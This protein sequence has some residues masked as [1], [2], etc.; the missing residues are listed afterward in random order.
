MNSLTSSN[1]NNNYNSLGSSPHNAIGNNQ[2][3]GIASSPHNGMG[4]NPHN[5]IGN[6]AHNGI[7]NNAHNGIGSSPHN[8]L[9]TN[10]PNGNLHN[11]TNVT[12]NMKN[13]NAYGPGPPNHFNHIGR[14][15]P[16][17]PTT[18]NN[19]N[20][21]APAATSTPSTNNHPRFGGHN[22]PTHHPPTATSPTSMPG[23][24]PTKK[25]REPNGVPPNSPYDKGDVGPP[26]I[27]RTIKPG[28]PR[29]PPP[30]GA[31]F[32]NFSPD[33]PDTNYSNTT[34]NARDDQQRKVR[35]ICFFVFLFNYY[36]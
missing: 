27:D 22:P 28:K 8:S 33:F 29:L 11:G 7:G 25:H 20:L 26:K 14:L 3:N 13:K 12:N 2:H 5:G 24:T 17:P 21:T 34:R 6:N 15:P 10:L 36:F 23:Y 30:P 4:N 19:S 1:A 35:D 18:N 9:G 32:R 16:P 31:E